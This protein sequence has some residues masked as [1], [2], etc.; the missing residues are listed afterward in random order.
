MVR[1]YRDLPFK[2]AAFKDVF[3]DS[4]LPPNSDTRPQNIKRSRTPSSDVDFGVSF[5]G[6]TAPAEAGPAY[7]NGLTRYSLP[8]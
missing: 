3:R 1:E 7:R 6:A 8:C 2:L 5:R 4:Q